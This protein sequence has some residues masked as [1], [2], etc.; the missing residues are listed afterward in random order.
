MINENV[1]NL[2]L[3]T[4]FVMTSKNGLLDKQKISLAILILVGIVVRFPRVEGIVGDDAFFLLTLGRIVSEGNLQIWTVSPF[5]FFALYPFS[6]YPIGLPIIVGALISS[7]FTY[8][9][10]IAIYS[11][12]VVISCTTGAYALS[13]EFHYDNQKQ[14]LYTAIFSLSGSLVGLTYF[15]IHP[16]GMLIAITPWF[17][18]YGLRF[19]RQPSKTR[20]LKISILLVLMM[21]S[22][23]LALYFSLFGLIGIFYLVNRSRHKKDLQNTSPDTDMNWAN[24]IEVSPKK[25]TIPHWIV[26]LMLCTTAAI[27]SISWDLRSVPISSLSIMDVVQLAAST[28]ATTASQISIGFGFASLFIPI[29][30]L[31][32]FQSSIGK[33]TSILHLLIIPSI[34]IVSFDVPYAFVLFMPVLAYYS[35]EGIY[36]ILKHRFGKNLLLSSF[37]ILPLYAILSVTVSNALSIWLV[38]LAIVGL[39]FL[40]VSMSIYCH[41]QKGIWD[42]KRFTKPHFSY[43]IIVSILIFSLTYTEAVYSKPDEYMT[44][45]DRLVVEYLLSDDSSG[46]T[47][48]N[49]YRTARRYEAYGIVALYSNS[50][51]M[52]VYYGRIEPS[53]IRRDSRFSPIHIFI[54]GKLFDFEGVYPTDVMLYDLIHLNITNTIERQQAIDLGLKYIV[55]D[56]TD[57]GYDN[58]F[59]VGGNMYIYSLLLDSTPEA[60][61][62]VFSTETRVIFQLM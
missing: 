2:L 55:L 5:S 29:G 58:I 16:R 33:S 56:V 36:E 31:V 45:D 12:V 28:G 51:D 19:L 35:V 20:F 23:G 50:Y 21:L 18:L 46:I 44:N 41:E 3:S 7:G 11:I 61:E 30:V 40:G 6:S 49:S 42:I 32:R 43:V 53:D 10:I 37:L 24:D 52:S 8:E 39:V 59:R 17:F 1:I 47:F 27:L 57:D 54:N 14:L 62:L 22:H 60:A 13:G 4:F 9:S 26:F 48:V 38:P 15:T 25:S 34:I